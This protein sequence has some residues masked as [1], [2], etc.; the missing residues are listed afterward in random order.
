MSN[1]ADERQ[2]RSDSE[3][4]EMDMNEQTVMPESSQD[5]ISAEEEEDDDSDDCEKGSGKGKLMTM[6]ATSR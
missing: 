1:S 3:S 2:N 4:L 6:V 5:D